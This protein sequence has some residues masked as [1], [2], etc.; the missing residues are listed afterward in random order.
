MS[1][2]VYF[3]GTPTKVAAALTAQSETMNGQSKA[4]YD[5]ALPHLVA[6]VQQNFGNDGE[7]VKIAANGRGLS[8]N[9]EQTQRHCSVTIE[10]VYGV[11]V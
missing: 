5:D 1:W 8:T 11:L 6:L 10:S 2:S 4:E 7:I 9:G 3:M